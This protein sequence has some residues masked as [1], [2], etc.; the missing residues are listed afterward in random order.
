MPS[1]RAA[2]IAGRDDLDLLAAEQA[3]L[4]GVRIQARH[5]DARL[6]H[7]QALER[8]VRRA[9]HLGE[10]LRGDQLDR[11]AQAQVQRRVHD[12]R[13]IETDHEER[14]L[15]RDS[16]AARD[17]RGVAVEFD[18]GLLDGELGVRR[19]HHRRDFALERRFHCRACRAH[20]RAPMRRA[21]LADLEALVGEMLERD[22]LDVILRPLE[23]RRMR[24]ARPAP[25]D[26]RRA[27]GG[28]GA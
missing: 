21:H 4:S 18:A 12:A 2:S 23:C 22:Q 20:R 7:A 5:R 26:R 6:F 10:A 13:G 16:R 14:V 27:P 19:G 24:P 11:A 1:R 15:G 17:E 3:G 25:P 8:V 28:I 9:Q